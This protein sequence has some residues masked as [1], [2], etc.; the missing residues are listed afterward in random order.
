MVVRLHYLKNMQFS[1]KLYFNSG[2]LSLFFYYT[3]T[4]MAYN[5]RLADDFGILNRGCST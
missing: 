4:G 2:A 5:I 1:G 3:P